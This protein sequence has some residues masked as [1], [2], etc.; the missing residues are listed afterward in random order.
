MDDR[1]PFPLPFE[2][3]DR[4]PVEELPLPLEVC[5][6]GAD[7]QALPEPSRTAQEIVPSRCDQSVRRL[8]KFCMPTG[9]NFPISRMFYDIYAK[10]MIYSILPPSPGRGYK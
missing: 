1:I 10:I 6:E 4:Q 3:G 8:S 7:Q 5:L 9:Y 2:G